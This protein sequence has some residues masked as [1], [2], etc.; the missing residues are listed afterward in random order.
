MR[1]VAADGLARATGLHAGQ[2]LSD[3][4]AICPGLIAREADHGFFRTMFER[5]AD[6]HANVSPI[7]AIL[8][9]EVPYGD[10]MLDIT[11]VAHLFGG[12]RALMDMVTA[13]LAGAGYAAEAAIA[14]S[15]GAAWALAHFAPGT[16]AAG[17][18]HSSP[19]P[20]GERVGVRGPFS[21]QRPKAPSP[22][23]LSDLS[24]KGEVKNIPAPESSPC[25]IRRSGIR[26]TRAAGGCSTPLPDW[27]TQHHRAPLPKQ[28]MS[29]RFWRHCRSRL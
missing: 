24:P 8:T 2:S 19:S 6:W 9:D 4:R 17:D 16:I 12:E 18:A 22:G 27:K 15:I 26:A 10:L 28:R 20:L 25:P 29:K 21:D 14:P 7:V 23:P 1:L 5:L 11:G 3:A 13:R